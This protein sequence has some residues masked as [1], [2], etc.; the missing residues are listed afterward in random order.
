M[1]PR[2]GSQVKV[3]GIRIELGEIE[4]A[5]LQHPSIEQ[6]VVVAHTSA[7]HQIYLTAYFIA[8][9][10][11]ADIELRQHLEHLLPAPIHPAFFVQMQRF[12]LNLHGKVIRHA[13]LRLADLLYQQQP[14][15][16]SANATE[17]ALAELCD[18]NRTPGAN[19]TEQRVGEK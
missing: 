10:S 9:Q 5:L 15:I 19:S 18:G 7:D 8:A 17:E 16:A 1:A 13:L 2:P 11:L 12:P 14:Y 6:A 4:Q 3:R